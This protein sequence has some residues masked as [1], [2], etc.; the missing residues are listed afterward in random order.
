MKILKITGIVLGSVILLV[1]LGFLLV[2]PN[3]IKIESYKSEIQKA[4]FESAKL[5]LDFNSAKLYTHPLLKIGVRADSPSVKY[6]DDSELF[7]ANDIDLRVDIL[8]LLFKNIKISKFKV[9]SPKIVVDILPDG[10]Y[11][12]ESLLSQETVDEQPA[13]VQENNNNQEFDFAILLANALID[14]YSLLVRDLKTNDN[15]KL[16]GDNINIYD[17]NSAKRIYLGSKGSVALNG[18]EDITFDF[19][20]NYHG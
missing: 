7:S 9:S 15:L 16:S 17:F 1:Y 6:P 2:L 18:Q 12:F 4:V 10:K 5:K 20:V 19:K 14:N 13:E 8:P 3:V 11:K